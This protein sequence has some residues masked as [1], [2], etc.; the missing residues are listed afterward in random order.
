MKKAA[1]FDVDETILSKASGRLY[2]RYLY[3]QGRVGY[4]WI[5]K[6]LFWY[7]Q[8]RLGLLNM[9]RMSRRTVGDMKGESEA[10]MVAL[11]NR[12]FKDVV[13]KYIY[14]GIIEI[15]SDHREKGHLIVLLTAATIY[16]TK[17]LGDYLG[18]DGYICN[19]L[20]VEDGRFTGLLREPICYGDG[21]I[22]WAKRYTEENNIDLKESF[23][24]TD[25]ITDLPV[26]ELVGHP[27]VVNPDPL[28]RR[29]AARREWPVIRL[30]AP[31]ESTKPGK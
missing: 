16:L 27:V 24:Y 18:V 12:W 22:Y 23:F 3:E 17:P 10:D 13:V 25:S 5:L 9:E 20:E 30:N 21:K 26:L 7:G 15:M 28:L 2:T 6:T 19:F 11:C 29:E 31:P 4:S 8:Y 14:P 1:F